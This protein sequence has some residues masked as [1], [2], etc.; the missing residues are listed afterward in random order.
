GDGSLLD[1]ADCLLAVDVHDLNQ[2]TC[3][4]K[5]VAG[6]FRADRAF[7][8]RVIDLSLRTLAQ[9]S[10]AHAG[11]APRPVDIRL[12]SDPYSTLVALRGELV[13]LEHAADPH[14]LTTRR[15][16]VDALAERHHRLR[17]QQAAAAEASFDQRPIA[18]PRMVADLWESVRH[19]DWLL[20]I[21]NTR[22]W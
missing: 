18:I 15:A 4:G 12:L 11:R 20:V 14:D 19:H 6:G 5:S 1:E 10:W 17:Q 8:G 9:G 7:T 16:R 21:R 3:G 13:R 2:L 22:S